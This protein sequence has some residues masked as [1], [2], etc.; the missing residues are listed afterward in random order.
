[1]KGR[2]DEVLPGGV[3]WGECWQLKDTGAWLSGLSWQSHGL[4]GIPQ[5]MATL[6]CGNVIIEPTSKAKVS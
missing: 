5:V 1:M 3:A 6:D 2:W 4:P